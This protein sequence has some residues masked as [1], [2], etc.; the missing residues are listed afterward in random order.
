MGGAA[1]ADQ[2]EA[3]AEADE[4]NGASVSDISYGDVRD[5]F[6][7]IPSPGGSYPFLDLFT[8]RHAV[9]RELVPD[10]TS[11]FEFGAHGGHFLITAIDACPKITRVAWCD[12]ESYLA[13]SNRL[14]AASI[15]HVFD[16]R[17]LSLRWF[18]HTLKA[19]AQR[20]QYDIVQVDGDHSMFG[21]CT[22]L[23]IAL[24][25]RPKIIM[26]DDFNAEPHAQVRLATERFAQYVGVEIDEYVTVNGLGVIRL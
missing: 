13:G 23:A 14:A 6:R 12:N 1:R 5:L 7:D 22:D 8:V 15:R 20:S 10:A 2:L 26:V 21:C 11:V 9:L 25:M 18:D 16:D 19:A 3:E 17:E 4:A 24:T